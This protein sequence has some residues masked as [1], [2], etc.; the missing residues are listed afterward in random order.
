MEKITFKSV[1]F[2][3]ENKTFNVLNGSVGEYSY[4]DV[5][6]CQIKNEDAKFR[7]NSKPFT[8]CVLSGPGQSYGLLERSFYVGLKVVMNDDEVIAIYVSDE[9]TMMNTSLYK[10]DMEEA[11]QIQ[12]IFAKATRKYNK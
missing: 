8:H 7:G 1:E 2:D 3:L 12:N 11:E 5:K 10:K 4:L 6:Q 9:K